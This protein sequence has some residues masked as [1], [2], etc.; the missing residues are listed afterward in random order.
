[1]QM[2]SEEWN[3]KKKKKCCVCCETWNV[4]RNFK[5]H[6]ILLNK[7]FVFLCFVFLEELTFIAQIKPVSLACTLLAQVLLAVW[8]GWVFFLIS[9]LVLRS[10]SCLIPSFCVWHWRIQMRIVWLMF[11]LKDFASLCFFLLI[12]DSSAPPWITF[13]CVW[14]FLS[15]FA[16]IQVTDANQHFLVAAFFPS[17]SWT[18]KLK[19]PQHM[20]LNPLQHVQLEVWIWRLKQFNFS[21]FLLLFTH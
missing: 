2:F 3:V 9:I 15:H 19:P 12:A 16:S 4:N 5:L 10:F 8:F 1:M 21:F 11:S 18:D 6:R 13:V 20:H 17:H 14:S 7:F